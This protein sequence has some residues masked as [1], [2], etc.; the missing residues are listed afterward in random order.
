MVYF[1]TVESACLLRDLAKLGLA[2]MNTNSCKKKKKAS[3]FCFWV[4]QKIAKFHETQTISSA[5][6]VHWCK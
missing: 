2:Q 3:I 6:L 1:P 5:F 4:S